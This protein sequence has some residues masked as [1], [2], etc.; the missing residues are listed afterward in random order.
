M[1]IETFHP[2]VTLVDFSKSNFQGE[3]PEGHSFGFYTIFLKEQKCGDLKYGRNYYDYQEGT[4]VFLAPDQIVRIENRLPHK[5]KG[6]ALMFHAD[7]IRGTSLGKAIKDYTFFS[8][9]VFEALHLSEEE[10]KT[11]LECF[12]NIQSELTHSIDKHSQRL[13]VSNIKLFLNY[14]TRYYD[15]QFITSI[16]V[17]SDIP[18]RS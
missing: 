5:P 6:W 11:I 17:N 10:R 12:S 15:T 13:I 18:S 8:Y 4:L 9:E 14:C 16:R 7:L 1:G 2:L 3:F